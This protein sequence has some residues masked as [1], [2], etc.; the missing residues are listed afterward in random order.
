MVFASGNELLRVD[1]TW[2]GH[3]THRSA[4]QRPK[5]QQKLTGGVRGL[6]RPHRAGARITYKWIYCM[7][8]QS[9]SMVFVSE[10]GASAGN[11]HGGGVPRI[12]GHTNTPMGEQEPFGG[13]RE[14]LWGPHRADP[15]IAYN[16][17]LFHGTTT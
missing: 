11:R 9:S 14:L 13:G 5:E 8:P 16:T 3:P 7:E 17:D 12:G 10:N 1:H 4:Q 6:L 15:R 2:W